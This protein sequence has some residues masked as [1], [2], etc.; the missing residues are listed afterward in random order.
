MRIIS[1]KSFKREKRAEAGFERKHGMSFKKI[2]SAIRNG[3]VGGKAA[4][5]ITKA[6]P[7]RVVGNLNIKEQLNLHACYRKLKE[8]YARQ[9]AGTAMPVSQITP[10]HRDTIW[11]AWLQ[12]IENAPLLVRRSIES[13]Q[14]YYP[15]KKIILITDGNFG[16]YCEIPDYIL[17]KYRKEIIQKPHFS[18]ILRYSL[19]EKNGGMWVD[20]TVICLDRS[21]PEAAWKDDLFLFKTYGRADN[22][23]NAASW[24]IG[25]GVQNPIISEALRILKEYWKEE[26]GLDEY[27]LALVCFT[28]AAERYS[29]LWERIPVYPSVNPLILAGELFSP[30]SEKRLSEIKNLSCVQKLNRNRIV[31]GRTEGTF[32]DQIVNKGA[33]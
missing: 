32:Y 18:D 12:G 4:R 5:Y 16:E 30:Y 9:A 29:G 3:S 19:L 17:Q 21:I 14:K 13:F 23:I 6:N 20:S 11:M 8:K 24:F 33:F 22:C 31:P 28:I 10:E 15:E 27:F 25:A 2:G 7:L 1:R 26:N